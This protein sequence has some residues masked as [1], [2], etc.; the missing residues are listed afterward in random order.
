MDRFNCDF[1]FQFRVEKLPKLKVVNQILRGCKSWA[2]VSSS[3]PL[4]H[5]RLQQQEKTL[6][7]LCFCRKGHLIDVL[8]H[9]RQPAQ[10]ELSAVSRLAAY[11]LT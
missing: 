10:E 9:V 5:P 7:S 8:L 3:P 1:Y 6:A 11:F 2:V 4:P